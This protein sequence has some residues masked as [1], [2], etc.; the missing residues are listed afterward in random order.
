MPMGW[1]INERIISRLFSIDRLCHDKDLCFG[2]SKSGECEDAKDDE[3]D[4]QQA[5]LCR[6]TANTR[7]GG[8]DC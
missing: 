8:R 3:N 4:K 6:S 5:A 7:C 2:M 1:C